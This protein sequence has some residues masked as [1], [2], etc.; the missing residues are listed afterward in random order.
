M[1]PQLQTAGMV[2]PLDPDWS[3]S[4]ILQAVSRLQRNRQQITVHVKHLITTDSVVEV[5]YNL[6]KLRLRTQA[7]AVKACRFNS[8]IPAGHAETLRLEEVEEVRQEPKLR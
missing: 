5:V 7:E 3:P 6:A 1:G 8:S 4:A 2:I